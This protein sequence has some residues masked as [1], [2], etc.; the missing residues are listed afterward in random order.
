MLLKDVEALLTAVLKSLSDTPRTPYEVDNLFRLNCERVA[1]ARSALADMSGDYVD[2]LRLRCN[3]AQQQAEAKHAAGATSTTAA[4]DNAFSLDF[5]MEEAEEANAEELEKAK[6]SAGTSK[7]TSKK[8]AAKAKGKKSKSDAAAAAE[9]QKP[10]EEGEAAAVVGAPS[11]SSIIPQ[12]KTEAPVARPAWKVLDRQEDLLSTDLPAALTTSGRGR[13][14]AVSNTALARVYFTEPMEWDGVACCC[15][16]E[17]Y[18]CVVIALAYGE[19]QLGWAECQQLVQAQV[20]AG[21]SSGKGMTS[22]GADKNAEA[23]M[24]TALP[25]EQASGDAEASNSEEEESA[26]DMTL[27]E[28][29]IAEYEQAQLAEEEQDLDTSVLPRDTTEKLQLRLRGFTNEVWVILL[30]HGGYFAGGVFV[31]GSCLVHKAFQRY[32]VRKKQGGK[33]SSNAKDAGSYNSVGS[34]IRAAQEVKWRIDVRDILLE[35]TPYIQAASFILYAAPG[36]QNRAVLTDFSQLPAVAAVNG[37]RGVSPIQLKDRRV[38][39]VPITTRRPNFEEVQRI[40]GVCSHC[41][42]LHVTEED[43]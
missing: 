15:A 13:C 31:R 16:V 36:P 35:W 38:S 3:E 14:E 39:R 42:L 41:A 8:S 25:T 7:R 18:R 20:A 28:Q 23:V 21:V 9:A 5:E 12:T 40:Y 17:L 1:S 33:Q 10:A 2:Q 37:A 24:S 22:K 43:G 32:V 29:L 26:E 6:A 30:C 27:S 4:A 34:Q 11:S 19:P